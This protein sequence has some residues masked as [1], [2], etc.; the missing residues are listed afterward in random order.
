MYPPTEL[1]HS[2]GRLQHLWT[3]AQKCQSTCPQLA[4][5]YITQLRQISYTEGFQLP[6]EF[7]NAYCHCC[8]AALLP[9]VTTLVDILSSKQAGFVKRKRQRKSH[10]TKSASHTAAQPENLAIP[11][12]YHAKPLS[13]TLKRQKVQPTGAKVLVPTTKFLERV[14]Q[15]ELRSGN[16]TFAQVSKALNSCRLTGY[17]NRQ[18]LV[19][20][21]AR[22][23]CQLCGT[24]AFIPAKLKPTRQ[25]LPASGPKSLAAMLPI[26]REAAPSLP[27]PT[28]KPSGAGLK[29]PTQGSRRP[30]VAAPT[31][32][33]PISTT[34]KTKKKKKTKQGKQLAKTQPRK[35]SA[36]DISL[37]GFLEQQQQSKT[38][39]AKNDSSLRD[40]LR[41]L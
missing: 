9:G 20:S 27:I 11:T 34:L 8:G 7:D 37:R 13:L 17:R 23:H 29:M 39:I 40:F 3:L 36:A 21:F 25:P 30:P 10:Q 6:S 35:D 2:T 24:N 16:R 22:Y 38:S 32:P 5:Y 1:N 33:L 26:T 14:E 12:Q 41:N 15:E 19:E 4:A 18:C 28:P 31:R